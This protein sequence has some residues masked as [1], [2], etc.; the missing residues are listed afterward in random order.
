MNISSLDV[1]GRLPVSIDC[2]MS[3]A[4]NLLHADASS[5]LMIEA[6]G[7]G[8][9]FC[10]NEYPKAGLCQWRWGEESAFEQW[11]PN[12]SVRGPPSKN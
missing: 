9:I 4:V 7:L 12:F 6:V 10:D 5:C 3:E 2:Y 1:S 11:F 8:T